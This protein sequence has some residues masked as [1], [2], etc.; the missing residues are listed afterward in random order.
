MATETL[1]F[2]K[3]QDASTDAGSTIVEAPDRGAG[4]EEIEPSEAV[5]HELDEPEGTEGLGL[6]EPV[7]EEEAGE[8]EPGGAERDRRQLA[9]ER[10]QELVAQRN[11]TRDELKA[12]RSKLGEVEPLVGFLQSRYGRFKNPVEQATWDFSFVD[13]ADELARAGDRDVTAAAQKINARLKERGVTERQSAEQRGGEKAPAATEDKATKALVRL[14]QREVDGHLSDLGVAPKYRKLIGQSVVGH[15]KFDPEDVSRESV[16]D[17]TRAWLKDNGFVP[18]DVLEKKGRPATEARGEERESLGQD[19]AARPAT[20]S[21]GR[22]GSVP[23]K[24]G[25]KPA[26]KPK[27]AESIE[28]WHERRQGAFRSL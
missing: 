19:R 13:A 1:T 7:S 10:I 9:R 22:L 21:Q 5:P 23:K 3:A 14:A 17:A 28:E 27:A 15:R 12:A 2:G 18:S 25:E 26:E 6:A 4:P 8:E 24:R 16:R 20:G 11:E